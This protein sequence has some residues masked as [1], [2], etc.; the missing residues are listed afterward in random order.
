MIQLITIQ[1]NIYDKLRKVI[2]SHLS[3]EFSGFTFLH[4]PSAP[5]FE[6]EISFADLN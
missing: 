6:L 4:F 2:L 5:R 1:L 3:V